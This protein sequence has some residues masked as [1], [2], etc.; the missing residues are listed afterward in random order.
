MSPGKTKPDPTILPC[1]CC[2]VGPNHL[3]L[4][5]LR[6]MTEPHVLHVM[7]IDGGHQCPMAG[8][9]LLWVWNQRAIEYLTVMDFKPDAEHING[10]PEPMRQ[11]IHDL[12]TRAD[13]AGDC[14]ARIT[15]IDR[16]E[17]LVSERSELID[18]ARTAEQTAQAQIGMLKGRLS[19]FEKAS[20]VRC[21][22]GDEVY[23][24]LCNASWRFRLGKINH[25]PNCPMY[26]G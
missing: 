23:C 8:A 20:I 5:L 1:P 6:Q 13:P 15:L 21:D 19:Q 2:G 12:E 25:E 16:V 22:D 11:F 9:H 4:Y 14:A 7:G 17:A 10:L 24:R 26:T 18:G 3:S